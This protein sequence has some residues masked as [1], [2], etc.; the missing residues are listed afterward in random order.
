MNKHGELEID[1][2]KS[3]NSNFPLTFTFVLTEACQLIC[4]Y[5]YF[6]GKNRENHMT[7]ETAQKG[8]DYLLENPHIFSHKRIV[9]D[10]IGGEPFLEV[11]L[12]N[13]ISSYIK[14]RMYELNHPWFNDYMFNV[15]TNGLLY[16]DPKVREFISN[17]RAHLEIGITIDGTRE[18][19]NLNRIFPNG[20][21]SYDEV[22]KQIPLWLKDFPNAS[23]KVTVASDDMPYLADSIIHLFNLGIKTVNSNVV[24]ENV[25]KE[26]DDKIFGEQLIKLA[27]KIIDD[28]YYIDYQCSFFSESIG[29]PENN[30]D[31]WCGSGRNMIALD[32][33]GNFY[34]CVRFTPFS[35][36]QKKT[37]VSV[38]N[39]NSGLD[40]NKLRPFL[41]LDKFSQSTEECINCEIASGCA[42]CV[43]FNYDSAA[44][45]TIY[46]RATYICKMHKARVRANN[47]FQQ[48]L[49]EAKKND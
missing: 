31:N 36:S 19:H 2:F 16:S 41:T 9:F 35:M 33:H 24:F 44:T 8:I 28:K 42:W 1:A 14:K 3:L 25:W 21:G 29:K 23:T 26:N 34:P 12:M 46:Q 27:D 20:K 48:R 18:K 6:A 45:D 17:N 40:F 13:K 30:N 47:Y 32:G 37:T 39:I 11:D 43:G 5:C 49:M 10:F 7:F 4:K 15:S 22:I 38:G